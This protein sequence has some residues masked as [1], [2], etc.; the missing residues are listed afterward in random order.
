M[1]LKLMMFLAAVIAA[2]ALTAAVA[3]YA[4]PSLQPS[5]QVRAL[6]FRLHMA[7]GAVALLLG[8]LQ[9]GP[10]APQRHRRQH[11]LL[12]RI[13]ACAVLVSGL[14]AL[15]LAPFSA[16]GPVTHLGFGVLGGLWL[17][18]TAVAVREI[19][20][21]RKAGHRRW[22]VRSYALTAAAVTLRID[23][24]LLMIA[25]QGDWHTSYQV[26]SWLCW[27]PNLLVAE[28]W[29]RRGGGPGDPALDP[30]VAARTRQLV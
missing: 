18:V 8:V 11:R 22:M 13:Y 20:A 1:R 4:P 6:L 3:G 16:E 23:L 7:S 29:L 15:S 30:S 21:G 24:P 25:T 19:R 17:V 27:V 9:F 28:L 5:Y 2:Y 10:F 14:A 26:V 12:G